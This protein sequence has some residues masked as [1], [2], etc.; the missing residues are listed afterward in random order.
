MHAY[1]CVEYLERANG[2]C[3]RDL[4]GDGGGASGDEKGDTVGSGER[5]SIGVRA[6]VLRDK[7]IT[8]GLYVPMT[9]TTITVTIASTH[10]P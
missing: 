1:E 6:S 3:V 7:T 8:D 9:P 5:E 4:H 2:E 10:V